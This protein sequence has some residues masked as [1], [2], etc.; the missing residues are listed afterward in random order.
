QV[1]DALPG[2]TWDDLLVAMSDP[3]VPNSPDR[4]GFYYNGLSYGA[5]TFPET[6]GNDYLSR[7]TGV[8]V[9]S[10]S[11][12]YRFF[13][14]SDDASAFYLNQTA[15]ALPNPAAENPVAQ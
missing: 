3:K 9:P 6:F 11:G 15:A 4:D 10:E 8:L 7:F 1:Y 12:Q 13:V 2:A 14:R 5:P